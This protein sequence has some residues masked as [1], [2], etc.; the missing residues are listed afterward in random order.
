MI[1]ARN[2][3]IRRLAVIVA[4]IALGYVASSFAFRRELGPP[5]SPFIYTLF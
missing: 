1:R 5:L 4:L 2:G 3:R